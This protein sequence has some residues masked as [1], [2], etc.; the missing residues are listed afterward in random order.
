[1]EITA[2]ARKH[3]IAD[4]D[5]LHAW[6]NVIATAEQEYDGEIRIIA[7]GPARDGGFLELVLV[8]ADQPTRVIHADRARPSF[9]SR[10]NL[11]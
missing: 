7:V 10:L 11:R 3:G 5:V 1:M 8:P 2:S 9:L 4:A 6:R